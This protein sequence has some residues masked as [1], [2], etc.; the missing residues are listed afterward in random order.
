ML[1]AG[2]SW[3]WWLWW[4]ISTFFWHWCL[5]ICFLFYSKSSVVNSDPR[6]NS[7]CLFQ[8]LHGA[9][10][11]AALESS[12]L[13]HGPKMLDISLRM[14]NCSDKC[15]VMWSSVILQ[16]ILCCFQSGSSLCSDWQKLENWDSHFMNRLD[17]VII[18]CFT[19]FLVYNYCT[20]YF[21][22]IW[23]TRTNSRWVSTFEIQLNLY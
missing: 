11:L 13:D 2:F 15:S 9:L 3:F 19:L 10:V 16:L 12:D 21:T 7:T 6:T 1:F 14:L 8:S 17:F 20:P 5:P 22:D 4:W 23:G 18:H